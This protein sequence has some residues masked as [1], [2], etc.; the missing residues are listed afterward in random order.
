MVQRIL[1][2]RKEF[3][4]EKNTDGQIITES[5]TNLYKDLFKNKPDMSIVSSSPKVFSAIHKD[6]FGDEFHI[7][8]AELDAYVEGFIDTVNEANVGTVID[9]YN[10]DSEVSFDDSGLD[11]DDIKLSL[12][13]SFKSLYDK[14]V[15]A[16]NVNGQNGY[17]FNRYGKDDN[18]SLFDHFNFI[19]RVGQDVGSRAVI[20]TG[21]LTTIADSS[22]GEGPTQ[23]LY[24]LMAN[25]LSKNNFDFWPTP[26]DIP[27][28]TNDLSDE[29]VK[30]M[31][32]PL[33]NK[34]EK[35]E[36]GPM[37]NCVY[38]AGSSRTLKD[39]NNKEG[40]CDLINAN[41]GY[42]DDS[43]DIGDETM[44][45]WPEDFKSTD[46]GLVA[47]KVR[48]GQESQSHFSSIELDQSEFKE[49]QESLL[50]I[51]SLTNPKSDNKPS[52]TGKGNSL[53]DVYL[54][55]SYNCKVRGLGNMSIQPLM[56]FKL[57]NVPMF[58]GTY[59]INHVSHTITPHNIETEFS[60]LR[61]PKITIPLVEE[62]VS[63]L[64]LLLEQQETDE[65][66]T[67]ETK[68][69]SDANSIF[70]DDIGE[71][72]DL[73]GLLAAPTNIKIESD[74][75]NKTCPTHI[76]ISDGGVGDAYIGGKRYKIRLCNVKD[77]QNG[78][79]LVNVDMALN[80]A[81]MMDKAQKDNIPLTIGSS[82]RT[83]E[84]QTKVAFDNNCYRSGT[85]R[86][87]GE[88]LGCTVSTALP[89][90]SN[91]QSGSAIDF[92]C[93]GQSIC[94]PNSSQWCSK[95]GS[96]QQ[97]TEFPC[98]KWMVENANQFSYYNYPKEAWHWSANGR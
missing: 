83:M 46:K 78:S 72:V 8:D 15:S 62:P 56:Y 80:L 32:R 51:D 73:S 35:Q 60:G 82:F 89:G 14:W 94:Y 42:D 88:P 24:T 77:T 64:D 2:L 26:A 66:T 4:G 70:G 44:T 92:G 96:T 40:N 90:N 7:S 41:N 95:Y 59:F 57:D 23:S 69:L 93:K 87:K 86:K 49:T 79:G 6:D 47:F 48:Y 29:D 97:P 27:I 53:H 28:L 10:K 39:L 33:D 65:E 18:R 31:F 84:K 68:N 1:A 12:Y 50:I 34:I 16:T 30:D 9:E 13:R 37:F 74:T 55:R 45:D 17:F 85:F 61:Q 21:F 91:H 20:D 63:I 54:T 19:N 67:G 71:T 52:Q 58:R 75:S 38:I 22:N 11:D 43:F 76:R 98:F 36:A 5:N 25:I 81:N 3:S